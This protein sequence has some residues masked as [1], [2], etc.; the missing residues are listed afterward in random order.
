MNF[1]RH[2]YIHAAQAWEAM[3]RSHVG[4]A[5]FEDCALPCAIVAVRL[6]DGQRV[7]F[8]SGEIVP[9]VMASTA[10]PGVFPPYRIGDELYV[11]GGVLEYM[12]IPTLLER[13]VTTIWA[14]DCSSFEITGAPASSVV[15][16]CSR[17]AS[18]MV[19]DYVTSVSTTRGRK[20]HVLRPELPEVEDARDFRRTA[21]MVL[22]GY[23]HTRRY[24]QEAVQLRPPTPHAS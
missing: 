19:V 17:I 21:D 11:D 1:A 8:D 10:I 20:V 9:A 15:E 13:N 24:L 22:A 12:P 16:R 2:G 6:S 23:E 5:R 4:D 18:S 3:L 14:L 7:V